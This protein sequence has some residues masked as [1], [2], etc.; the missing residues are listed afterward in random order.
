MYD[1][2]NHPL[3]INTWVRGTW[4][5]A[6]LTALFG[7]GAVIVYLLLRVI[8][9][10]GAGAILLAMLLGPFLGGIAFYPIWRRFRP[11]LNPNSENPTQPERP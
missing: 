8:G 11:E 5:G 9:V 7:V 2:P 6:A 3:G 4:L 1:D 10:E